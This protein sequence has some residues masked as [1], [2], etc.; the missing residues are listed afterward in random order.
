MNIDHLRSTLALQCGERIDPPTIER[1]CAE[2]AKTPREC[3]LEEL[4]RSAC[5]IAER[6]G[7]GTAWDRF[8]ASA[9]RFGLNDTTARTFCV[10]PYDPA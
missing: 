8:L 2:M 9:E 1:I 4:V 6:K 5:A 7:E 10:L 3:D